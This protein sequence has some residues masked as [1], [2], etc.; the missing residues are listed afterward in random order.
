MLPS[1]SGTKQP[2]CVPEACVFW[3]RVDR[4]VPTSSLSR[5]TH[6]L[7]L[8]CY[9]PVFHLISTFVSC[10][11]LKSHPAIMSDALP[12]PSTHLEPPSKTIEREDPGAGDNGVLFSPKLPLRHLNW[13]EAKT[14]F[15]HRSFR[16]RRG[17]LF[18][19]QRRPLKSTTKKPTVWSCFPCPTNSSR[20]SRR[21]RSTR[22]SARHRRI[23]ETGT[24]C[25][26]RRD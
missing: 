21:Q 2:P 3:T 4:R 13:W 7:L 1:S 16:Q 8:A 12:D 6:Y 23:R 5:Y 11:G 15:D 25:S 10:P 22:R 14:N 24:G 18:R 20:A 17:T 26:S 19:C 9:Y